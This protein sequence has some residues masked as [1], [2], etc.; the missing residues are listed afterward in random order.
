MVRVRSGSNFSALVVEQS[1]T[2]AEMQEKE[3]RFISQL[4]QK[5]GFDLKKIRSHYTSRRQIRAARMVF[6][7]G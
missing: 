2:N 6:R 7:Y 1:K 4:G 3:I 5:D